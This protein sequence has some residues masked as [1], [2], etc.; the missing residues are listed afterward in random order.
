MKLKNL[1]GLSSTLCLSAL[2][3]QAQETNQIEQLQKQLKQT[4]ESFERQ[5]RE[6]RERFE[7]MIRDQQAQIEVLKKQFATV[8]TNAPAAAPTETASGQIKELNEKVDQ[9]VE[10]QKKVRPGEFNPSIGLV[11]ETV[12]S[13]NSRGSDRTG[14]DR[15]GGFDVFQRS[16][17]EHR[18]FRWSVCQLT[19]G[20]CFQ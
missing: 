2:A 9:V 14:N 10:A 13:Y 5:Q 3:L 7:K 1:L 16:I 17:A 19:A 11:G 8:P 20:L 18:G 4:Q 6:M 15:P 12:F